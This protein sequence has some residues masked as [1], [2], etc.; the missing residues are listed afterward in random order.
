MRTTHIIA[1]LLFIA[2]VL[3][4]AGPAPALPGSGSPGR[5]STIKVYHAF[6]DSITAVTG[7]PLYPN[8]IATNFGLTLTNRAVSGYTSDQMNEIEIFPNEYPTTSSPQINTILIG[9]NDAN[10]FGFSDEADYDGNLY[11]AVSWL[12]VPSSAKESPLSCAQGGGTWTPNVNAQPFYP[13]TPSETSPAQ[14]ATLTCS[15]TVNDGVLYSWI[16]ATAGGA[17]YTYAIDSGSSVSGTV[18]SAV[19][20]IRVTGLSAGSHTFVLTDTSTSSPRIVSAGI[21]TVPTSTA[22]CVVLLAGLP[23]QLGDAVGNT[24]GTTST[25][26][27]RPQLCLGP[28]E[29]L[30]DRWLRVHRRR[31]DTRGAADILELYDD[32]GGRDRDNGHDECRRAESRCR[33][34]RH[35]R[36]W[37]ALGHRRLLF[38]RADDPDK[39]RGRWARRELRQ[40][41]FKC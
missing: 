32:L 21:G 37:S 24:N 13:A 41:S 3:A 6:G 23:Y 29:H 34:R 18:V 26:L 38:G 14:N 28:G 12:A 40:H 27:C 35:D 2:G 10:L 22:C 33:L 17:T 25:Q 30:L 31:D 36:V 1:P 4:L 39:P 7:S 16:S 9:T 11:A 19:G 8:Q 15:I 5:A 20:L